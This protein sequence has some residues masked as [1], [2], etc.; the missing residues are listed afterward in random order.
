MP[1][2]NPETKIPYGVIALNNLH[3]WLIDELYQLP[4][5]LYDEVLANSAR[6]QLL[7][8]F[9]DDEDRCDEISEL[10]NDD[11][12]DMAEETLDTG[13]SDDIDVGLEGVKGTIDGVKVG[14]SELGGAYLLWVFESP[15]T[16]TYSACSPCVPGAG[17][18]DSPNENGITCYD[19]PSYWRYSDED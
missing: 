4:N 12:L 11:I 10:S 7:E 15:H 9:A 6:E 3:D 14:V 19:V 1:N 16:G 13:W 17:D 2:Y 8:H 18:L 5:P